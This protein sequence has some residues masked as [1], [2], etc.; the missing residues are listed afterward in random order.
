LNYR[1]K[2]KDFRKK[3]EDRL[4]ST[5][6]PHGNPADKPAGLS[7]VNSHWLAWRKLSSFETPIGGEG[8]DISN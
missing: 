6:P 3:G 8:A 2:K 1:K 4:Q 7:K 5:S